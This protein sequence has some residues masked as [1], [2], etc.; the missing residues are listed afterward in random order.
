MQVVVL[1]QW[2]RS[3]FSS[4]KWKWPSFLPSNKEFGWRRN[5]SEL[6][7]ISNTVDGSRNEPPWAEM[8][9][10]VFWM[11]ISMACWAWVCH[12]MLLAYILSMHYLWGDSQEYS[13]QHLS[14]FLIFALIKK[15]TNIHLHKVSIFVHSHVDNS[16]VVYKKNAQLVCD[17]VCLIM[18]TLR[19]N[20]WK[21]GQPHC[22]AT[23]T[24]EG[25][26]D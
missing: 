3:F 20:I 11:L 23:N 21:D 7:C 13:G 18:Q 4:S 1:P 6:R 12:V 14:L 16:I 17:S 8:E 10:G 25:W 15:Q 22:L 24:K 19:L 2:Y 26:W 9:K 5:Y